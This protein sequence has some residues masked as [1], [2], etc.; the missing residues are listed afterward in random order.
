MGCFGYTALKTL[1]ARSACPV[2]ELPLGKRPGGEMWIEWSRHAHL[3]SAPSR[4]VHVL[5]T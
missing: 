3:P 4:T 1:P 2:V 5:P